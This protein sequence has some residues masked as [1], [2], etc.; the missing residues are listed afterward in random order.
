[1]ATYPSERRS[2]SGPGTVA[3][4]TGPIGAVLASFALAIFLFGALDAA[5]LTQDSAEA[6]A[7][8]AAGTA[9][10]VF[11]F[12]L[13]SRLPPHEQRQV[14]AAKR[15]IG[16][17]VAAALG[18]AFLL[19]IAAGV[20]VAAGE[21]ID[22]GLSDEIETLNEAIPDALWHKIL[23]AIGLVVLAPV[24]EELLFRGLLLRGLTRVASFPVAAGV[25]GVV[26]A[27]VHPQYWTLWP[28]IIAIS[29]FGVVAAYVY[30][31]MGYP[32]SMLMHL[33]FNAAAAVLLFTGI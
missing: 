21:Q 14:L 19:R 29:I 27:V 4:I 23:L 25:S 5:G 18:L 11:G 24:G 22:P 28:L 31:R 15:S 9:L 6:L 16:A 3:R 2:T 8:L 20:I 32:A 30:R 7:G 1:M 10:V 33:F 17:C 12:W 13:R 26:F